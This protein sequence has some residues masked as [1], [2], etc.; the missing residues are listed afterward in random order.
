LPGP[1]GRVT[2]YAGLLCIILALHVVA[3]REQPTRPF[4]NI[5]S[6]AEI[7]SSLPIV[8][9]NSNVFFELKYYGGAAAK[10]VTYLIP[11]YH[12]GQSES[13]TLLVNTKQGYEPSMVRESAFLALHPRFIYV[14]YS[15]EGDFFQRT[16]ASD[17]RWHSQSLG[18]V[19]VNGVSAP[20]LLAERR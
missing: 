17:P 15:P 16:I 18:D 20:L 1:A 8:V 13:S 12:A 9:M 6:L 11:D 14:D 7:N 3:L 5:Q 4:S 10:Q 19:Q 2:A